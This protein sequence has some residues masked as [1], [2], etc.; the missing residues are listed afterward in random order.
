MLQHDLIQGSPEWLA[1]RR[2]FF[3]ASDAPVMMGC[4]PYKTLAQLLHEMHTGMTLDVNSATQRRF[5]DGH[6]FEAL[7]RPLAEGIIG[8]ELYPVV[9]T[10]GKLSASSD[11]LTMGESVNFEHKS[12]NDDL[13]AVMTPL[14]TGADLPLY[15]RVQ[16]EQQHMVFGC[17]K[18]LFMASKWDGETLVEERHCWYTSN[19]A[20]ALSI[21][22]GWDQLEKDVA[23]YVPPAQAAPAATGHAPETL[24][25]LFITVKGEVTASNLADFKEVALAAIRSVNRD[26]HTD[27]DFADADSAV[28]WC[29]DIEKRVQAAKEH[30]L[31]QT[32]TIDQLFKTMDDISAEA[33]KVRLDLNKL[34]T[35]RKATRKSELLVEVQTKLADH[36]RALNTRLGQDYMP[37][38]AVDFSGAIRGKSSFSSMTSALDAALANAKIEINA[39]ADKIDANLRFFAPLTAQSGSL[40]ADIAQLVLKPADDFQA[41]VRGRIAEHQ[42]TVQ[43]QAEAAAEK[44]R[45]AIRAEEQAKAEKEVREKLER[46]RA[47]LENTIATDALQGI[48]EARREESLP[49]PLLDALEAVAVD[50]VADMALTRAVET[51]KPANVVPIMAA[52]PAQPAVPTDTGAMIRLGELNALLAPISL[53]AD[54]LTL[55]GFPAAATDK[56]AKLYRVANVGNICAALVMHLETVPAQQAA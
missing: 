35:D 43:R 48:Q 23:A 45:E 46:E 17:E 37:H 36:L 9:G 14:C 33:R 54:G 21:A 20:L 6:R 55:L 13:R 26:L 47:E 12:L 8:E 3:N 28:K 16:V 44:A 1:H 24:P 42:A 22:A 50:L 40:F 34:I 56:N 38:L 11:G 15:H 4:S 32:A 51:S 29:S 49:L 7:A 25:A 18:T 31:S 10:E 27:Q 39:V 2:Q 52:R 41:L 30:A 19:P 5:D 53:T